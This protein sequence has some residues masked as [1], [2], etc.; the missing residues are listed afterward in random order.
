LKL[1]K[2]D[3][4]PRVKEIQQRLL[5][6]GFLLGPTHADGNFGEKTEEAVKKFQK[7]HGIK[8]TGIVDEETYKR[9]IYESFS[10]GDRVL[11]LHYP[12]LRGRDVLE[13][14]KILKNFGFN[15]G[16]ID[17]I[18][19]P[20][21]EK[22]VREFQISAGIKPDGIVGPTTVRQILKASENFG[23]SSLVSYPD[24]KISEEPLKEIVIALDAGHGGDDPGAVSPSGKKECDFA[25]EVA[26]SL[27]KLLEGLGAR[28]VPVYDEE[29]D[30][31][32]KD[33]VEK[34]NMAEADILVSIHFNS[35][36][37]KKASGCEVLYYGTEISFSA[38][39]KKLAEILCREISLSLGIKCRGAKKRSDLYLLRHTK[40]PAVIVE[41][42]F[43]SNPAEEHLLED[44]T[45]ISRISSAITRGILKFY[46]KLH[47]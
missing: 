40:M 20:L 1:K 42:L 11:Y 15:P 10:L 5:K 30:I 6:I 43:L 24:R 26:S 22:A 38:K 13:L 23:S 41:P 16:P 18:Y 31:S 47:L 28:V 36:S 35:A 21:T 12:F 3:R 33:R 39:G 44:L 46:G 19:G 14:Q 45:S 29:R 37:D 25:R 8:P 9:L 27:K 32:L 2:G 34:A 17:G 7:K 4:G